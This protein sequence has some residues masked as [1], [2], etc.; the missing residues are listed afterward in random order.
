MSAM[1]GLMDAA[2]GVS[3]NRLLK[4]ESTRRH[5]KS[6]RTDFKKKNSTNI[7]MS[8]ELPDVVRESESDYSRNTNTKTPQAY[9]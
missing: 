6:S 8:K 1:T 7:I 5:P 9:N 3:F 2:F 4:S